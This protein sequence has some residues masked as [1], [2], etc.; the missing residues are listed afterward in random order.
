MIGEMSRIGRSA[1]ARARRRLQ[2]WIDWLGQTQGSAAA[3]QEAVASRLG[4]TQ[5]HVSALLLGK[6]GAGL[7][8]SAAIERESVSWPLGPIRGWEWTDDDDKSQ[9]A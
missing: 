5:G 3:T 8:V 4:C 9:A 7:K 2:A 6:R 1:P